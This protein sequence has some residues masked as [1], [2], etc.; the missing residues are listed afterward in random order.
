MTDAL[1]V[2]SPDQMRAWVHA[3]LPLE[4]F[5]NRRV[6]LI[7]PDNTRTAPL[8]V[9]FP[10][11][12]SLLRPI[13]AAL[14]VLVRSM[15][16]QDGLWYTSVSRGLMAVRPDLFPVV[17]ARVRASYHAMGLCFLRRAD[18]YTPGLPY[19]RL[20]EKVH[21][22]AWFRSPPPRGRRQRAVWDRRAALV[23]VFAFQTEEDE[24]PSAQE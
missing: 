20:L 10:A 21:A 7:I 9:L 5:R 22:T 3:N 15:L 8:N 2:L 17:H 24:H 18:T 19:R 16:A 14:D 11:I 12:R 23:A 13:T 4:D 1:P 6:L